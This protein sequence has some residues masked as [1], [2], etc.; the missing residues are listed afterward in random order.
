MHKRIYMQ[1]Q[2]MPIYMRL[3]RQD[4]PHMQNTVTV[5]VFLDMAIEGPCYLIS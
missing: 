3:C 4:L 5:G 1:E 2:I